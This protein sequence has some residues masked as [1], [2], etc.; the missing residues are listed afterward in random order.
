[1]YI[2]LRR[3]IVRRTWRIILLCISNGY[4]IRGCPWRSR[5]TSQYI[6]TQ[7]RDSLWTVVCL[8]LLRIY[9][10]IP[11]DI[12][13]QSYSSREAP[14]QSLARR[15]ICLLSSDLGSLSQMCSYHKFVASLGLNTQFRLVLWAASG[16]NPPV[17]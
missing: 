3:A 12:R 11:K 17:N 4:L 14:L 13:R 7:L 8:Y 6:Q 2:T 10:E 5:W 1:M 16:G 9:T 15:S